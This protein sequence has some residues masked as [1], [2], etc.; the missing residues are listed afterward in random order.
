MFQAV[1]QLHCLLGIA[2]KASTYEN[3]MMH[4][5]MDLRPFILFHAN[6]DHEYS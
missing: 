1:N 4:K 6:D 3:I 2:D 5:Q